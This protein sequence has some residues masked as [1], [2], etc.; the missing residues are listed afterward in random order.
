MSFYI[1][2]DVGTSS[3]KAMLT[4]ETEIIN[5]VSRDYPLSMPEAGWSEQDPDDWYR[6]S[7]AAVKELISGVDKSKVRA[8]S[9]SGQMHGLVMLDKDDRVIRPAILWNDGRSIKE[10][11]YLNEEVGRDFLLENTGNIAFAGFTAPK[12]LWVYNNERDNFD[13]AEK[14]C[15]PKDYVAFRMS[16]VFATDTSDAAGTLYFDTQNRCW[17]QKMLSLLHMEERKLPKVYESS[18]CIGD[19]K[20]EL[21]DELGLSRD[22]KIIIG[23]GDN[24]ASAIGTGTVN[25]GDCNISLGTSGTV[26][27]CSDKFNC[28]KKNAIHSFCSANGKYHYLACTLTAA[29]SQKWWVE[30]ILKSG[31]DL[32][33]SKYAGRSDVLFLPYLMG[34]RSPVNDTLVRG[35]FAALS[36]NTAREE[37]ALAVL[38]GVAFSLKENIE[39]IKNLGV[40]IT[41]SKICG[42]GTKNRFWVELCASILGIDIELPEFEH[43]G[44]LG[45]CILAAAGCGEDISPS[46]CNVKEI[47]HPDKGL[48][49]FY[50]KKYR[51]YLKLYPLASELYG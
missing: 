9:F 24:A 2:I 1:G 50:E 26:F 11:E 4:D 32:D 23:A 44:V 30:D 21:A 33:V 37:M 36:M 6:E 13:R 49:D 35:V 7:V 46:F 29:S 43:G 47:I 12:L 48:A 34:E 15:L 27:V 42:G 51:K 39:I 19:L 40:D 25:D 10:T 38:E 20:G 31:Y 45:A 17:S 14:I 18:D 8:I 41:R 16:G 28:D 5:I 3:V 22:V